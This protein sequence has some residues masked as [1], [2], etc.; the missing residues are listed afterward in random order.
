MRCAAHAYE[1]MEGEDR[2]VGA[3][4]SGAAVSWSSEHL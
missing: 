2:V 3:R 1:K 4:V